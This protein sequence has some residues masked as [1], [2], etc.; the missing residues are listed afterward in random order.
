MFQTYSKRWLDT[1]SSEGL[2]LRDPVARWGLQ[3]IGRVRW[4]EL[5]AIDSGGVME[6]AKDFGLM[7][8]VAIAMVISGS[9]SIAG[10][11]R[12][13]RE[14][15]DAEIAEMEERVAE[16]HRLTGG[17]GGLSESDQNALTAL[18]VKLTHI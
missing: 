3:N 17:P 2:V 10:F 1:Y 6:R 11:S 18:S 13:D 5:E 7:N 15:D 16:L 14:Y 12:A 9:R 8:G 4:S